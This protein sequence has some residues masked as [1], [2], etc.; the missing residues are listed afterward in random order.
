M[1]SEGGVLTE[2]PGDGPTQA[3]LLSRRHAVGLYHRP[4]SDSLTDTRTRYLGPPFCIGGLAAA[5]PL[6]TFLGT[7]P[8]LILVE[9]GRE[10]AGV[11][12]VVGRA[13]VDTRAG[14]PGAAFGREAFS[15][16]SVLIGNLV[17]QVEQ[18]G[19]GWQKTA[20]VSA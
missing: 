9:R 17:R 8:G 7:A 18:T 14:V 12:G 11:A 10:F 15:R 2:H 6:L 13:G 4:V 3:E 19:T 16:C 1:L 20:Y 5:L